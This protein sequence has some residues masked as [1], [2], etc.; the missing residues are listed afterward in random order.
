MSSLP[1][2]MPPCFAPRIYS[3]VAQQALYFRP[4]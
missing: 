2:V 4:Q 1:Q 3:P